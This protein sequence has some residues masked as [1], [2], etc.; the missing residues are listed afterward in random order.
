ML[1]SKMFNKILIANRGE[2]ACRIIRTCQQLG[3]KTVAVCSE[4]D[5][6][7]LHTQLADE[8]VC[9]GPAEAAQSYLDMEKVLA[10][11]RQTGAQAI[12]PGY[13][14]LSENATFSQRCAEE[15]IVFIGP[16]ANAIT[17][18]G[19]K[20][21]AKAMMEDAGVPVL[22]GYHGDKQDD[23]TLR[24]AAMKVGFPLMLK[25]SAG[26][27]GKG[28]RVVYDAEEIDAAIAGARREA[29]QAFGDDRM[30]VEKCLLQPRHVEIQV[31]CDEHGNGVYL[32]ERDCS[33]QRRHQKI[34][35]EAPAPGLS[36]SLRKDMGEAALKAAKAINYTGA[37][38]VEFLLEGNEFWFMEMNTR[39]QVEHPVTEL[40]TGTDLVEWQL[41]V[42]S[43]EKLPMT[44][45]QLLPSGHA[46]EVRLYAE[47]PDNGFLP[48][49]GHIDVLHEPSDLPGIRIDSGIQQ[50]DDVSVWYDPMLSKIIAHGADR[51][52]ARER[53]I[54]ALENMQLGGVDTNRDYLIRVLRH[55]A[56]AEAVLTT[57]FVEQHGDTLGPREPEL[58]PALAAAAL[59]KLKQA[60]QAPVATD[61]GWRLNQQA[62]APVFFWQDQERL[63]AR[64]VLQGEDK[65]TL[66]A[67]EG[68]FSFSYKLQN[69]TAVIA[70]NGKQHAFRLGCNGKTL[71]LTGADHQFGWSMQSP[72]N[73]GA[74]EDDGGLHAPMP[75]TIV[76]VLAKAGTE[77]TQ[78]TPLVIMEAMKM[79]HTIRAPA[80][81]VVTA[82]HFNAGEQVEQNAVLI[83][84]EQHEE[85]EA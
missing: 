73:P 60:E 39:L 46:M 37:G 42:A 9:L 76:E 44:Q 47:S 51:D 40:I 77:V 30:L 65:A 57:R 27:G 67:A 48:A 32:F 34:I 49:T 22:P 15:G 41:L 17:A 56:F 61:T 75:G 2:I 59:F 29:M 43:G 33:V 18:M 19:S 66:K 4:A 31:F 12:H 7:A 16:K 70:A 26:G 72:V 83:D 62:T 6:K 81:G 71:Y 3:V 80:N 1:P 68:E 23:D 20:Q 11:A 25:A 28:M 52:E 50:G 8:V 21:E 54:T 14:F 82:I 69:D 84:F 64:I 55:K 5:R 10:A 13:G 38:T 53:L 45:Q 24:Q 63:T 79:E 36:P 78:D 58:Q 35:E 74:G 85:T